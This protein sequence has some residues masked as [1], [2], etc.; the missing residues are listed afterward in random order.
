M[1]GHVR[2]S[3]FR[4]RALQNPEVRAGY[5]RAD[6]AIRFGMAVRAARE[7]A[8]LSQAELATRIG[9]TQPSLARLEA[10]GTDP[11][12]STIHKIGDALG[13]PLVLE[14]RAPEREP[15]GV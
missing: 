4:D 7:A 6:R 5:E 11:K 14:F 15:V 13:A 8:G 9:S 3:T 2:W 10:G 12:L 1:P